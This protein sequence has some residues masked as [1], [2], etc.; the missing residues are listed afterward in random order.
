MNRKLLTAL[1]TLTAALSV[2]V[3]IGAAP[4][5][6]SVGSMSASLSSTAARGGLNNVVVSGVSGQVVYRVQVR[7]GTCPICGG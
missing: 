3:V 4:A 2:A 6:A 7:K 1:A 5:T